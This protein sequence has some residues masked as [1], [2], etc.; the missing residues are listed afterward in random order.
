M[1]ALA[2]PDANDGG[3]LTLLTHDGRILVGTLA[4]MNHRAETIGPAWFWRPVRIPDGLGPH[5]RVDDTPLTSGRGG[6]PPLT[7]DP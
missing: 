6:R 3:N 5:V 4:Q 2:Y 7:V 1:Y